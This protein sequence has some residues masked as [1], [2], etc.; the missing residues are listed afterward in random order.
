MIFKMGN[1]T[2]N[3]IRLDLGGLAHITLFNDSLGNVLNFSVD[4]NT[5]SG[6]IYNEGIEFRDINLESIYIKSNIAGAS[7]PFRLWAYGEAR[8]IYTPKSDNSQ[9]LNS[10]P[11]SLS[12]QGGQPTYGK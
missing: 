10:V 4:G 1:S 9:N 5:T 12:F 6:L 11:N 7:C 2:D 8:K 3:Y